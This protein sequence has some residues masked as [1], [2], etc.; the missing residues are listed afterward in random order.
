MP[1]TTVSARRSENAERSAGP[2]GASNDQMPMDGFTYSEVGKIE[3]CAEAATGPCQLRGAS[4]QDG[5]PRTVR[6]GSAELS[7][8]APF[9]WR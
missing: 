1:Q 5:S 9:T 2:A 6:D 4:L 8:V 7:Y 3:K